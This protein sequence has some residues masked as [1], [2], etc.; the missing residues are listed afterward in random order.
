[1]RILKRSLA[2][3]VLLAMSSIALAQSAAS[4]RLS[5]DIPKQPLSD[6]LAEWS[7]QSGL[8]ILVRDKDIVAKE[9]M[10]V[11]VGGE[12]SATEALEKLLA[13]T[14]FKYEFINEHTVRITP[15]ASEPT[16]QNQDTETVVVAGG[17][18]DNVSMMKRGETI[19]ETPQAVTIMTQQRIEEQ[20][21]DSVSAV[22][23]Q[24]P[25]I[26]VSPD[27]FGKSN[28]YYSRGFQITNMQID[29]TSIDTAVSYYF[30]PNLAEYEQVEVLRGAD[31]LFAGNGDPGGT[32]N[33]SRK[34]GK[35]HFQAIAD[36]SGGSWD[37]F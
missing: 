25:G 13:K 28:T 29:G 9:V 37:N 17:R 8:Q 26:T 30:N 5:F 4:A 18:I 22:L 35:D 24:A 19:R 20:K 21:L 3:A 23:E 15:N 6:A 12:F 34:R 27:F 2:T 10:S 32:V 14:G 1:M 11:A 33:L 31:G 36:V 7:K 16:G